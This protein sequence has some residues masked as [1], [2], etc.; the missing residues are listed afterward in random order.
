MPEPDWDKRYREGFYN[1]ADKPHDLLTKFW[2]AIPRGRIVDIAMGNG[3][4]AAF[5]AAKGLDVYGLD[6]SREAIKIAREQTKHAVTIICGDAN[7]LP[8]KDASVE[9]VMVFYF[10]LRGAMKDMAGMLKKG[11]VLIYETF[12]KR[13]NAI[14]RQRNPEHLLDDGE[15]FSWFRGFETLFYEETVSYPGGRGKAIA[16]FVGR[17]R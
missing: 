4:D 9:G 1:G 17:K 12:L 2:H 3:R 13:Q 7:H 5:L 14:D 11:G 15:L 10:L 16:R 6:K 8:F